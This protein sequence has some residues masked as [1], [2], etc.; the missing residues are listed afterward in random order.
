MKINIFKY[1][2]MAMIAH[3]GIQSCNP[4]PSEKAEE[5]VEAKED[6]EISQKELDEAIDDSAREESQFKIEMENRLAENEKKILDLKMAANKE[7]KETREKY[8]EEMKDL[9]TKNQNLK[10]KVKDYKKSTAEKW[11]DFK[12]SVN[13]EMDELGKSISA[14]AEKNMKK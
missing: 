5:V 13:M 11:Q 6:L 10:N 1:A 2:L 3:G 12:M 7:R 9:E 14:R 4:K 8:E